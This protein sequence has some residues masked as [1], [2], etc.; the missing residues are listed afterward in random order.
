MFT[1]GT[2][3]TRCVNGTGRRSQPIRVNLG[4]LLRSSRDRKFSLNLMAVPEIREEGK[5]EKERERN[6][7][8]TARTYCTP[9]LASLPISSTP[10]LRTEY[11][12]VTVITRYYLS[13]LEYRGKETLNNFQANRFANSDTLSD[14]KDHPISNVLARKGR[15]FFRSERRA[16]TC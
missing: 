8:S 3:R 7:D 4:S 14:K 13:T 15:G 5:A 6:L 12:A 11:S 10:L 1:G 16:K 2:G 9:S